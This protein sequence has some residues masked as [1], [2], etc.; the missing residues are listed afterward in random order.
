MN[1]DTTRWNPSFCQ[2]LT[3]MDISFVLRIWRSVLFCNI[4]T[5]ISA[6]IA[7]MYFHDLQK[8]IL[9][10]T[11]I[12]DVLPNFFYHSNQVVCMAALEVWK[13]NVFSFLLTDL[14]LQSL[15]YSFFQVYVRRAYIAYELNSIQHHR[16][17]DGTCAVDFQFMLPSSHPN[18]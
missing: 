7:K 18:R 5:K 13:A 10:E 17:Q 3:C 11:S 6:T 12:F 4:T 1:W 15:F 14:Y 2:L 16:L 8:L 9:S